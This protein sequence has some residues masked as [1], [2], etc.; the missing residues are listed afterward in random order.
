MPFHADL[1][2]DVVPHYYDENWITQQA[3]YNYRMGDRITEEYGWR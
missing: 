2:A 1:Y 3:E